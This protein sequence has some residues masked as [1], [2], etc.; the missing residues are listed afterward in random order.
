MTAEQREHMKKTFFNYRQM[1]V[2]DSV[3]KTQNKKDKRAAE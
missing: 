3:L 2:E 1:T